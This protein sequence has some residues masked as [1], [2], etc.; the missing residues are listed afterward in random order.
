M[1]FTFIQPVHAQEAVR[2]FGD[3][4]NTAEQSRAGAGI[5]GQLTDLASFLGTVT[6]LALSLLGLLFFVLIVYAG[7]LWMTAAGDEDRIQK[8]TKIVRG[9]IIG[10]VLATSAWAIT[11]LVT[12]AF[13]SSSNSVEADQVDTGDGDELPEDLSFE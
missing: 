2:N 8:A 1:S 6:G 10:L 7:F 13:P 4:F 3:A 5:G 12:A 9:T 11:V